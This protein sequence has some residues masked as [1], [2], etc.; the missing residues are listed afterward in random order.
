MEQHVPVGAPHIQT[1]YPSCKEHSDDGEKFHMPLPCVDN[2][3]TP[4]SLS[5]PIYDGRRND[6]KDR[7]GFLMDPESLPECLADLAEG[8]LPR[9]LNTYTNNNVPAAK[10]NEYYV[11]LIGF[12]AGIY[13]ATKADD[14]ALDPFQISLNAMFLVILG[15]CVSPDTP[16]SSSSPTKHESLLSPVTDSITPS[17]IEHLRAELYGPSPGPDEILQAHLVSSYV[18]DEALE[19]DE[20]EDEDSGDEGKGVAEASDDEG[21]KGEV[22]LDED[23]GEEEEDTEE[24]IE[25]EEV[26]EEVKE[27]GLGEATD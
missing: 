27:E 24:D 6:K 3:L 22:A 17:Y 13:K 11:A 18:D 23:E 9:Y 4:Y 26:E 20:E 8:R 19:E 7:S 10:Q 12:T 25:E 2:L 14:L 1:R 5:V 15:H 21:S 16:P